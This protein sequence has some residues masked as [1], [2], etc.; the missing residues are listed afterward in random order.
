MAVILLGPGDTNV[1]ETNIFSDLELLTAQGK[2]QTRN[3]STNKTI[4][5]VSLKT[6]ANKRLKWRSTPH[7]QTQLI[8]ENCLQVQV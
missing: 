8:G 4:T 3:E 1:Y 2:K 7:S 5:T 6:E